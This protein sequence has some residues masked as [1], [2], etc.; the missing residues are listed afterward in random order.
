MRILFNTKPFQ[1]SDK[2]GVGY[3]VLNLYSRLL[4]SGI[5]VV[6][7]LDTKSQKMVSSLSKISLRL[8]NIFGERYSSVIRHIGDA[9]ISSLS[10]K[11]GSFDL[12]HETTLDP[13]P[14][15]DIPRIYT[16]YDLSFFSCPELLPAD[17]V[18]KVGS[19]V[20]GN[21]SVSDRIIV[22]SN[23]VKNELVYF[24]GV[25][26][27]KIDVIH[28]APAAVFARQAAGLLKPARLKFTSKDYILYV[29]T[30]DP[31]KNLKT[32]IMAFREISAEYDLAL[33]IAGGL[34]WRSENILSYPEE[35]GMK[36]N[37]IFTGYVDEE[38]LP[39][40]YRNALAFVYP[41]LY[42]GFGLPPLEAMACGVPVIISSIP[43]LMEVAGEA[44][45]SF[46]PHDHEELAHLLNK[47]ISSPS[48][49][50]DIIKKGLDKVKDYSWAKVAESTIR[51]YARTIEG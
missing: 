49:R 14:D 15:M 32:L 9:F 18:K 19:S 21:V 50:S 43:P 10:R 25:P 12:Y 8:R 17:F 7:T 35:L 40:L 6:P 4:D 5:N 33:I 36:D 3:Y 31:R 23:F 24:L 11:K 2:T 41:S 29:G 44:A 28:L 46:N 34:G 26:E 38:I 16:V 30:I 20:S 37:V 45:L 39:D 22:I 51:T 48:L 42:E 47:V 27:E 1:M 13:M